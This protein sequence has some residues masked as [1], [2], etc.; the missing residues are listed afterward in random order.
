MRSIEASALQD[1]SIGSRSN[2][3][4]QIKAK[5]N[6]PKLFVFP[7]CDTDLETRSYNQ[8]KRH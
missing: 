8:N 6:Q 4:L 2:S 5:R 1:T 7:I 3:Q